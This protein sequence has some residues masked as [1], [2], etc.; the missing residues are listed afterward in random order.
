MSSLSALKEKGRNSND[1]RD[2]IKVHLDVKAHLSH[3]FVD[4]AVQNSNQQALKHKVEFSVMEDT[5][6][7]TN[8]THIVLR[9]NG[10]R[11]NYFIC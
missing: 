3:L 9:F 5:G 2:Y 6:D 11:S 4:E 7:K 8:D 10:Q 1:S